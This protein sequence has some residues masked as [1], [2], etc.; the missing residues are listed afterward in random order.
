MFSQFLSKKEKYDDEVFKMYVLNDDHRD[1]DNY[2]FLI[3]LAGKELKQFI[4]KHPAEYFLSILRPSQIPYNNSLV[5]DPFADQIFG[6]TEEFKKFIHQYSPRDKRERLLKKIMLREFD[7]S[8]GNKK[9]IKFYVKNKE[10]RKELN[11]HLVKQ[12]IIHENYV[13]NDEQELF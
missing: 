3:Q 10:E 2:I 1:S 11:A 7:T 6:D 8:Y 9:K 4:Y 12:G 13:T 5:F